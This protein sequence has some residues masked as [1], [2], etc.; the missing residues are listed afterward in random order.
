MQILIRRLRKIIQ[1]PAK[2]QSLVETA[3]IMPILIFM[4]I[5]VIEVGWV[6]RNYL[7]LVNLDR[8]LAR[9]AIR[10]GYLD[11]SIKDTEEVGY[12]L[13]LSHTQTISGQLN[14]DFDSNTTLIISHMVVDTGLPCERDKITDPTVCTCDDFVDEDLNYNAD[15][16]FTYDDIILHPKTPGFEYFA[17]S[18]PTSTITSSAT[19]T[20]V[21]QIDYVAEA[22]RLARQ[23]NRL[24]CE[25]VKKQLTFSATMPVQTSPN[26]LIVVEINH[27]QPQLFGF[28]LISNPLTD[29]IPLY[30][31]TTM[32]LIS[33][34]R[35]AQGT[36][37]LSLVGPLCD[38]HPWY[39]N[40]ASFTVGQNVNAMS[41]GWI[42]WGTA[43]YGETDDV[44]LAYSVRHPQMAMNEFQD[45][46]TPIAVGESVNTASGPS[47]SDIIDEINTVIND[48]SG[49]L[50]GRRII[51][52]VVA[53]GTIADFAAV[54]ISS[55]LPLDI[56][57]GNIPGV[58]EG[59]VAGGIYC[60][61][62]V[63]P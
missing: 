18:F 43:N 63:T 28:P 12:N 48:P 1:N 40:D 37:T 58:Y 4:M 61:G 51:V 22:A 42:K 11:F 38:A 55:T 30:A 23:N 24:N 17:R 33:G 41:G 54:T 59:S 7:V 15:N 47:D 10:P 2:G 35:S 34:S 57:T 25:L 56:S 27:E 31:R 60:D 39:M 36:Q 45:G 29:P 52:P 49:G 20:V 8:E 21:S 5:G 26:N 16:T 19:L 50:I 32:R 6:L 14:A 46:S 9:F 62:E 3:V 13:V 53:G 44:Y